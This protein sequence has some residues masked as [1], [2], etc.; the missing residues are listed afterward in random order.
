VPLP[1]WVADLAPYELVLSI[2]ETGSMG[3][4]AS[5]HGISQAAV[6][7]RM[8]VLERGLGVT[9]L[10]RSPQG[11]RLTPAGALVAEWARTL[12]EAA[13]A[14]EE[15]VTALRTEHSRQLRVVASLT[16]A[17][18]LLPR[19]LVTLRGEQPDVAVSLRTRNSTDVAEDIRSGR[20][21]LGFV[22]GPE[23]GDDLDSQVVA[24][25]RLVVVVAP[26]H[27]W[28]RRRSVHAARLIDTPL[29]SREEGSGTREILDRALTRLEGRGPAVPILELASTTAIKNAVADG[30]APAVLST[31]AV[32]PELEDGRLVAIA[33]R[34]LDLERRL[35]AV[36][37]R[38]RRPDGAAARLVELAVRGTGPARHRPRSSGPA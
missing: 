19:W 30:V 16:I 24:R 28:A 22:E 20:A 10:E 26:G 18:Y 13:R 17:E 11:T 21:D 6:S 2:M 14:L 38:G 7:A 32:A 34:G 31:L 37:P 29:I 5:K 36:W 3:R 27:A 33:V 8:R 4:T 1:P 35:T 15:G 25:D 12:V 9:V 23:I